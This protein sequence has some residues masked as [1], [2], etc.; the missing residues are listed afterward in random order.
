MVF[1]ASACTW[2]CAGEPFGFALGSLLEGVKSEL[3]PARRIHGRRTGRKSP[4]RVFRVFC[5]NPSCLWLRLC[6]AVSL[7]PLRLCFGSTPFFRF[8]S[9]PAVLQP[10]KL[11]GA[12]DALRR[13][14][15]RTIKPPKPPSPGFSDHP[16]RLIFSIGIGRRVEPAGL[17]PA[18][19]ATTPDAP[20][21]PYTRA[22][23]LTWTAPKVSIV[24]PAFWALLLPPFRRLSL[25]FVRHEDT[26]FKNHLRLNRYLAGR[27]PGQSQFWPVSGGEH[28]FLFCR[29][30]STPARQQKPGNVPCPHHLK[31]RSAAQ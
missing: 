1:D 5:G 3:T 16:G 7:A 24:T 4:F 13:R 21:C 2:R 14:S 28:W 8:I 19:A 17:F 23:V 30:G 9:S 29:P 20:G 18:V 6:L 27:S 25:R 22:S 31:N 10:P 11:L 15:L 26:L 12:G